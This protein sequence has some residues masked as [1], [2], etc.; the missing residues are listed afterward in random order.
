MA[1]QQ[2]LATTAGTLLAAVHSSKQQK[3]WWRHAVSPDGTEVVLKSSLT[4]SVVPPAPK[5]AR[6]HTR[7]CTRKADLSFW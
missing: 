3:Q 6:L 4:V 1:G 2:V 7:S 5:D